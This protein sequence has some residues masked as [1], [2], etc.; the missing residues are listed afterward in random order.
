[1]QAPAKGHPEIIRIL[2]LDDDEGLLEIGKLFLEMEGDFSVETTTS[3]K[4]ALRMIAAKECDA[5]LSDYQ[6]PVMNG[7]EFLKKVRQLDEN[8]PFIIFTG[9]GREE[10]VIEALNSG[11]DFYLQKGGE[12]TSQF[13]E[14]KNALRTLVDRSATEQRLRRTES[15]LFT[16]AKHVRDVIF[17]ISTYPRLEVEYISPAIVSITGYEQNE[18][19]DDPSLMFNL[20]HPDDRSLM[21]RWAVGEMIAGDHTLRWLTKENRT[22]WI[23]QSN[24]PI[25]DNGGRAIAFEGIARD[26]TRRMENES[27]LRRSMELYRLMADNTTDLVWITDLDHKVTYG[28]P[29]LMWMCPEGD[30]GLTG[31]LSELMSEDTSEEYHS[32][33]FEMLSPLFDLLED[34]H[35][36]REMDGDIGPKDYQRTYNI[37]FTLLRQDNGHPKG[38]LSVARDVTDRLGAIDKAR[39]EEQFL[40]MILSSIQDGITVMDLDKRIMMVNPTL[41]QWYPDQGDLVGKKCHEAFHLNHAPCDD[42]PMEE[43]LRTGEPNRH[44]VPRRNS[45]G[46]VVGWVERHI[47]PLY[48]ENGEL[49]GRIE[50]LRD[51][52]D[53]LQVE[54]DLDRAKEKIKILDTITRHD[55]MN[56]LAIL[57]GNMQLMRV[58]NKDFAKSRYVEAMQRSA[59]SIERQVRFAKDYQNLGQNGLIWQSVEEVFRRSLEFQ[60]VDDID[61]VTNLRGLF[62]RSDRMVERVFYNLID[63]TLEHGGDVTR[64]TLEMDVRPDGLALIYTDDGKGVQWDRKESIFQIVHGERSGLGLFLCRSILEMSNI[65]IVENGEP[66]KGVRFEMFVTPGFFQISH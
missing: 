42:C 8:I 51:I 66:G 5:V 44:N 58:T 65:E 27:E 40:Q 15:M 2:Y 50:Y 13:I 43:I 16:M 56:Q 53:Q 31:K 64:I 29:S 35:Q 36:R 25:V 39:K 28:S 9:R 33:I 41:E 34:R 57:K 22:I 18:F 24:V 37:K 11:A 49:T 47:F 46:A 32:I 1:M 3:P 6:M 48:S 20:I 17:R 23:E 55:I 4:A 63:N 19:Y 54:N 14:L 30:Y 21:E 12:P 26:V 10:V 7:I 59:E 45:E 38:V 61:I 60:T 62:L 52:S